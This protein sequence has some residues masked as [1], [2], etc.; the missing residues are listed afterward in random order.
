M[1]HAVRVFRLI[2]SAVAVLAVV[3]VIGCDSVHSEWGG[4][5][6]VRIIIK[7]DMVNINGF[8]GTC[9]IDLS[10][11]GILTMSIGLIGPKTKDSNGFFL[12]YEHIIRDYGVDIFLEPDTIVDTM[13]I[14][15][16][17]EQIREIADLLKEIPEIVDNLSWERGMV[18]DNGYIEVIY[19]G[20]IYPFIMAGSYY[21]NEDLISPEQVRSSPQMRGLIDKLIEYSKI[22]FD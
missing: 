3:F 13:A 1:L 19:M 9:F 17:M 5:I 6:S 22:W 7:P 2:F 20:K 8:S 10:D 18:L 14:E 4:S 16:T 15:L 11:E 21:R 12:D